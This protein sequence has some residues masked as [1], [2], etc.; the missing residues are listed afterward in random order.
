MYPNPV[1]D[2]I[3]ISFYSISKLTNPTLELYD[4]MGRLVNS[5]K[6]N[7]LVN[8][9]NEIEMPS[10]NLGAGLYLIVLNSQEKIVTNRFLK[11][12]K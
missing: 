1:V 8:G 11:I 10:S 2:N 9:V 7:S 6:L 12:I 3:N 4:A 5:K